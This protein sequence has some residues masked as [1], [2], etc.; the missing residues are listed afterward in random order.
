MPDDKWNP[1][2]KIDIPTVNLTIGDGNNSIILREHMSKF[3]WVSFINNGYKIKGTFRDPYQRLMKEIIEKEIL[4]K[5]R[6]GRLEGKFKVSWVRGSNEYSSEER[7]VFITK[8]DVRNVSGNMGMIDVEGIDKASWVLNAGK[9]A[10]TVYKGRVGGNDGVIAQVIK[11]HAGNEG[12]SLGVKVAE[13]KDNKNNRWYM[14][15]MDPKTFITSLLE[16]SSSATNNNTA[17]VIQ[18]EDDS[19]EIL[20]IA[21]LKKPPKFDDK[22]YVVNTGL[23]SQVDVAPNCIRIIGNNMLSL[24]QSK[25]Y[26]AGISSV[27]GKYLDMRTSEKKVETTDVNTSKKKNVEIG[28]DRGYAKPNRDW[29]TFIHTVPEHNNGDVGIRYADYITG[30]SR[31]YFMMSIYTS[32]RIRLTI[33]GDPLFDTVKCLGGGTVFLDMKDIEDKPY[34]LGGPWMIYGF[35]HVLTGGNWNTHLHLS[36]LDHDAAADKL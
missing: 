22:I 12:V 24:T 17:W 1:G 28:N 33:F 3:E 7:K 5:A 4:K 9:S 21:D 20:E 2:R 14:M 27:T 16:W 11:E 32:L 6:R 35:H 8:F 30:R 18:S 19:I 10:G 34:F 23:G 15:R 13:T 29:S 31:D 26:T 36:R 25:L